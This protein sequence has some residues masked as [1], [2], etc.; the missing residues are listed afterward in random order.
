MSS[1]LCST[2]LGPKHSSLFHPSCVE[3]VQDLNTVH[4]I[5]Q[6][7]FNKFRTLTQ[8]IIS[9]KLCTGC[10][11]EKAFQKE[12]GRRY[13]EIGSKWQGYLYLIY[14]LISLLF[15]PDLE[16]KLQIQVQLLQ[17]NIFIKKYTKKIELHLCPSDGYCMLIVGTKH[18]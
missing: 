9:S 3:Q 1:R 14:V 16:R 10:F 4:Y 7:V 6:V 8:F 11:L 17:K 2:S 15:S 18:G 5:I 12:V 13:Q